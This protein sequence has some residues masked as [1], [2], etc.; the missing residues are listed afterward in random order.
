MPVLQSES[1]LVIC[2]RALG[3][4]EARNRFT[5]LEDGSEEARE[6]RLRYDQRRRVLLEHLDWR[7]A[8]RRALAQSVPASVTPDGLPSAW[9]RPP[10]CIRIRGLF[11]PGL[12]VPLQHVVEE[13]IYTRPAS[14][15]Q[16]VFTYDAQNPEL[17]P[18]IF[19]QALEH[20]L[21]ADFALLYA[22][23]VNRMDVLRN[24]LRDILAEADQIE[25]AERSE[26]DAYDTG[27]W[28]DAVSGFWRGT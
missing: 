4:A 27:G 28:A 11:T 12:S 14:P 2:Q 24:I 5:S 7:F 8:R 21:A 1:A 18:P 26:D 25:A 20:L 6:A 22:R 17:F 9:A 15:V 13:V 23:S 19:T 3:L 10:E 16:I